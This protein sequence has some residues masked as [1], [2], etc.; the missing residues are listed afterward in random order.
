MGNQWRSKEI[1][2]TDPMAREAAHIYQWHDVPV[3]EE[4]SAYS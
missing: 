4:A 3:Q 2:V 1:H